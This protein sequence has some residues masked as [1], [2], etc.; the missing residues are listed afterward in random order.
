MY[1][2]LYDNM[3]SDEISIYIK[4]R[5]QKIRYSIIE[6]RKSHRKKDDNKTIQLKKGD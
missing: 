2:L 5:E 4:K 6:E 3:A 1:M